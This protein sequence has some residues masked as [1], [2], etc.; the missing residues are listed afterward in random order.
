MKKVR[1]LV[2][3][4][5][6]AV[7]DMLGKFLKRK[8]YEVEVVY[9]GPDAI[10]YVQKHKPHA[11]LLDIKMPGM[12]GVE[13]LKKILEID[14]DA[15]VIMITGLAEYEIVKECMKLGACGYITKPLD[16]ASLESNL[17]TL[18]LTMTERE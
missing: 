13:A 9:T 7:C 3:D 10:S 16:L 17:T 5:D 11:I 12:D 2:A 18:L 8:S 15:G 14:K 1:V 6:K 4:D